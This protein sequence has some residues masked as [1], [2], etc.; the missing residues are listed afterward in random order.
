ME[1]SCYSR[2][3]TQAAKD[4]NVKEA[5]EL[6]KRTDFDVNAADDDGCSALMW[7][8]QKV[9]NE[10][11]NYGRLIQELLS[12]PRI[13]VNQRYGFERSALHVACGSGINEE[14]C[15]D[16]KESDLN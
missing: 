4:G 10:S 3:L 8:V 14:H 5:T 7:A 1:Q 6:L 9:E 12:H 15:Y 2:N 16:D 13:N 11:D